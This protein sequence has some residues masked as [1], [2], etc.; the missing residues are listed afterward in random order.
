MAT[1]LEICEDSDI[2][3]KRA[4]AWCLIDL[5]KRDSKNNTI[6]AIPSYQ[7]ELQRLKFDPEEDELICKHQ[8]YALLMCDPELANLFRAKNLSKLGKFEEAIELYESLSGNMA[9]DFLNDYGWTLYK[10]A[11]QL[12]NQDRPNV[13]LAKAH[14]GAYLKLPLQRPSKLHSSFLWLAYR[15]A[16]NENLNMAKF[17]PYWGLDNFD[18]D[19]FGK[20]GSGKGEGQSLAELVIKQAVKKIFEFPDHS[21]N[22]RAYIQIL[23]KLTELNPDDIWLT[24]YLGKLLVHTGEFDEARKYCK[25]ICKQK[26]GEYWTWSLLGDAYNNEPATQL[27]YYVKAIV[28]IP[29]DKCSEKLY[30]KFCKTL[31]NMG[32]WQYTKYIIKTIFPHPLESRYVNEIQSI[33]AK[34]GYINSSC[35]SLAEYDEFCV[36]LSSRA[37]NQLI[38]HL[39]WL[40]ATIGDEIIVT[41]ADSGKTSER[42]KFI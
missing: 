12:I 4:L 19:D 31:S 28:L 30:L 37:H 34:E 32:Y 13:P 5:I 3:D 1:Q 16:K 22:G 6:K 10:H 38:A 9:G 7:A 41:L 20:I 21:Y 29:K 26:S 14:M 24:Y 39:P 15:I 2:W 25:E 23:K 33:C 42:K 40:R 17:L 35:A 8:S 27:L 18:A 11:K 36:S